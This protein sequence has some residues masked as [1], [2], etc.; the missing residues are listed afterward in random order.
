MENYV[1]DAKFSGNILIV[2]RTG[3]RKTYFT[4]KLAIINFFGQ[5]KK[6]KWVSYIKLKVEREDE[7]E[8]CFS[9][10]VEFHYPKRLQKFNDLL[11]DFKACSNPAEATDT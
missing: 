3:C 8:S 9:C 6:V 7:V 11:E 10:N 4:Q 2:G 1:Y 5:L